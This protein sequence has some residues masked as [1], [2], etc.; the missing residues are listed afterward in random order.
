MPWTSAEYDQVSKDMKP[1][2]VIA[3]AG[4][5]P[6]SK[7]IMRTTQS[8]VSHVGVILQPEGVTGEPQPGSFQTLNPHPSMDAWK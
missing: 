7:I 6:V 3:F 4:A 5:G 1:G 8:N 2:D